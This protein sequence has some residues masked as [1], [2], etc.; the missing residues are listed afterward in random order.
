[1]KVGVVVPRYGVEVHGGAETAARL[2]AEH[3]VERPG[4]SAEVFT[5]GALDAATW[6]DVLPL[7]TT[8]VHGVT[9]H[10]FAGS[11]RRADFRARTDALLA[12]PASVPVAD[13]R[14][15]VAAQG[16][17]CPGALDA[18]AASDC[19]LVTFHPYLYWPTVEGIGRLGDRA[20]LH[21]A[22]HDEAP[23]RLPL[24]ADVF[25][26]AT[27]LAFWTEEER[28]LAH[29]LFPQVVTHHQTVVGMGVDPPHATTAD[30]RAALGLDDRPYLLCL[31]RVTAMKGTHALV[32]AFAAFRERHAVPHALVLAGPVADAPPS[33]PDVVVAGAVDEPTK[34][35]LLARA[36]LLVSPSAHESLSL[37]L[38]EAWS[39][40]T[41]VLVNG[42]CDATREQARRASGG[43]WYDGYATFE[44]ALERLLGDPALRAR[45]AA[46][47][48]AFVD[49]HCRWPVVVDRY[50]RFCE[51]VVARPRRSASP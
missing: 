26:R 33:H 15:W 44:V 43:L 45:L 46:S 34:W 11:E 32:E 14:D 5:T 21:P 48:R 29:R 22:T 36:D 13:A 18:A 19:D 47:G 38:L 37:V 41:P 42:A 25:A 4:W 50:A 1:V 10:R 28:A 9:V 20:V 40:G 2:L 30:A 39:A 7:G 12:D 16:P 8:T 31:G 27:G 24:F 51:R 23:I 6:R 17:V 3:L 49:A 35:D